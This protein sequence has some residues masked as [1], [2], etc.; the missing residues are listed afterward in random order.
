MSDKK[1]EKS[2]FAGLLAEQLKSLKIELA[3]PEAA[4]KSG[5]SAQPKPSA[6]HGARRYETGKESGAEDVEAPPLSDAELFQKTIQEMNPEDIYRGKYMGEGPAVESGGAKGPGRRARASQAQSEE[7]PA[8]EAG[9]EAAREGVK[10]ARDMLLFERA[11]SGVEQLEGGD[12]YRRPHTR[13]PAED[14]ERRSAY[15]SDSPQALNTPPLPKSGEGLNKVPP[16]VAAQRELHQRYKKRERQYEVSELNVRGDSV[17]DALRQVEL[18]IHQQ[19]K[20]DGRYVRIIH[21]RGLQSN[22][23]PVLKPAILHWLEGPGFRYVRGY[24]P[25]LNKAGDY[26]SLIVELERKS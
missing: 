13:D 11:V 6:Q 18:F 12:K 21:G 14:A 7:D 17:E 20:R 9:D 24:I 23:D 22:G 3:D 26:G 5:A 4:E 16:L 25:E 1:R 10:E 8:E 15:R 19:W 2:P